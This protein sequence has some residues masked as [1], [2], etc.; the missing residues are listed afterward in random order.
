LRGAQLTD[1]MY[2]ALVPCPYTYTAQA[3]PNV[4][5]GVSSSPEMTAALQA[6]AAHGFYSSVR[7]T[8]ACA[9]FTAQS[10]VL[11]GDAAAMQQLYDTYVR[12][13]PTLFTGVAAV[14]GLPGWQ[15]SYCQ[16]G[17]FAN[18]TR[19]LFCV[20]SDGGTFVAHVAIGYPPANQVP[21]GR[22]N[23]LAREKRTLDG[24]YLPVILR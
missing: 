17:I 23:D 1:Q 11:T 12:V 5:Q 2:A 18:S 10:L 24:I 21:A 8:A 15:R 9:P 16:D 3:S 4:A 22:S 19:Y 20:V 6:S 13:Y 14:G 7:T